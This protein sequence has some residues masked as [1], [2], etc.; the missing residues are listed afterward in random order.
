MV[1]QRHIDRTSRYNYR[2]NLPD[3]CHLETAGSVDYNIVCSLWE[4]KDMFFFIIIIIIIFFF[5]FF[6]LM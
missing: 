5:F 1:S 2:I 3:N 6:F 4:T